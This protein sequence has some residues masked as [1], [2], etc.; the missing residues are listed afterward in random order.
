MWNRQRVAAEAEERL[1]EVE[2]ADSDG[3]I[4]RRKASETGC[5][6][7]RPEGSVQLDMVAGLQPDLFGHAAVQLEPPANRRAARDAALR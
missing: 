4:T 7:L 6:K 1:R 2:E 5:N 3:V